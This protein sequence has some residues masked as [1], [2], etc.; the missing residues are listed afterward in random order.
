MT[1]LTDKV[2]LSDADN[3][4]PMLEKDMYDSWKSI[5]ELYMMKKQHGRMILESVKN[6]PLIWPTIKENGVTRPQKYSKLTHAEAIQ[7]D[8]DVKAT[9]VIL[10]VNQQS[11]Q[12]EFPQLDSGLTV[13]VFKKGDDPTNAINHMMSFLSVAITSRYPTTNN[14]LG[15]SSNP[16]QQATINDGRVTLEPVQER[17]V[18]FATDL[19]IAEGQAIQTI[20][21]HNAAYQADDL[22]GYDS[23]CD[24]LN[25]A[26]VA[27]MANLSHYGSDVLAEVKRPGMIYV[28]LKICLWSLSFVPR[29]PLSLCRQ[30][31]RVPYDQ[32]NNPQ[33]NSRIVYSPVLNINY[34][35][36]FLDIIQNYDPMDD[37]P[38]WAA[39]R[40][41]A[42][43]LGSAITILETANEFAIKG[44]HLTLVKG[45]QVD[46]RTKNDPHKH[47]HKFLGICDM[48]KYRDTKNKVVRLMMFPLSLTGEPKIWLD[49]LNEGTFESWDELRTAFISR[50]FAQLFSSDSS[51]KSELSLNMKMNL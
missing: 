51:E 27:L 44:K 38:M 24:E 11:Q 30:N 40:I 9:N 37:E 28:V 15:N 39:D 26:K 32:R 21:T 29:N 22:D 23:D 34:F 35:H 16:R 4:P 31:R 8:C 19:G 7:A 43:T 10:Q 18:S 33:Q 49:E 41:V 47:I 20:I 1:A 14:Q 48:F 42:L 50:F 17:Q 25:T 36:N 46:G 5:M 13:P 12:P 45:N 2:I 6:G 3:R